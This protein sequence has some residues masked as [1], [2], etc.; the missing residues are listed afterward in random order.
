MHPQE[1]RKLAAVEDRLWWFR[2]LRRFIDV[3]LPPQRGELILDIGCGTG[4]L[5]RYFAKQG[6]SAVGVDFSAHALAHADGC[7][8]ARADAMRLPFAAGAFDAVV[9]IDLLELDSVRPAD[10]TAEAVR[11]LRQD[12]RGLLVAAAHQWLLSEHDRAVHSVRRYEL[13]EL[14]KLLSGLPVKQKRRTYLFALLFPFVAARK[15]LNPPR[16]GESSS[17]VNSAPLLVNELLVAICW[18]EAQFLRVF[19]LPVGSSAA[20]L[21]EKNG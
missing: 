10:L 19:S 4:G 21:V 8:V 11:V 16:S 12:G 2:A 1:Y 14:R 20:V 3:L 18:L 6:R 17:D 7:A 9:C 5:L 13:G 15:L